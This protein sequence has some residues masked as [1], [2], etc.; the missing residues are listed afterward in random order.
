MAKSKIDIRLTGFDDLLEK[1][2][3]AG[4]IID[5][6]AESCVKESAQIVKTELKAQM[7]SA[8][9]DNGLIDR[10]PPPTFEREGNRFSASVGYEKGAFDPKNLS[11][12]Y[13]IVFL[14]YGTPHRTEHGKIPE[15]GFI[16]KAKK[17]ATAKVKKAQK[18]T[19]QKIVERVEIE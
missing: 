19:L 7:Q 14:N 10:M 4:N 3:S 11:D 17:K 2:N 18:A 1:T 5:R 8:G 12:V 16:A 15:K 6:A 9:V 13:K